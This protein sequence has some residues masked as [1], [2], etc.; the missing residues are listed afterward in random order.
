[1]AP[2]EGLKGISTIQPQG[3]IEAIRGGLSQHGKAALDELIRRK[4][5]IAVEFILSMLPGSGEVISAQESSRFASQ[6]YKDIESGEV[7]KGLLGLGESLVSAVGVLPFIGGI[8]RGTKTTSRIV[9]ANKEAIKSGLKKAIKTTYSDEAL[10]VRVITDP[11]KITPPPIVKELSLTSPKKYEVG[12]EIYEKSYVWNEEFPTEQRRS[13]VSTIL[14]DRDGSNV[15][16]VASLIAKYQ[17][18]GLQTVIVSG[19]EAGT[20]FDAGETIIEQPIVRAIL[21]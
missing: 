20:G 13:G 9:K 11:T 14:L 5:P 7:G 18:E 19:K 21:D 2:F 6:A 1:M 4:G 8:V 17:D 10:G 12:E 3:N 15:D 16:E